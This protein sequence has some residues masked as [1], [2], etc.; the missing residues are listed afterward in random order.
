MRFPPQFGLVALGTC[1]DRCCDGCTRILTGPTSTIRIMHI[2]RNLLLRRGM[3]GLLGRH[4]NC[5]WTGGPIMLE[6]N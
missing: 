6:L 1:Q 4:R 2:L 5:T 3:L